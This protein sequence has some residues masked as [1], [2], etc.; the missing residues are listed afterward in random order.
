[1]GITA[2][3]RVIRIAD[4][5]PGDF[6][7][8]QKLEA[9]PGD[10]TGHI[11]MVDSVPVK[12]GTGRYKVEIID[13]TESPHAMDTRAPGQSGVGR[14]TIWFVTDGSGQPTAFFWSDKSKQPKSEPIAIGRAIDTK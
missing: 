2:W 4:A 5:R 9:K 10:N 14:G 1:S 12:E 11:V 3:Q 8:W 13:S 7:A 6:I